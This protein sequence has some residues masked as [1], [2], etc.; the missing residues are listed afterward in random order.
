MTQTARIISD[1]ITDIAPE[2]IEKAADYTG[3]RGAV[4]VRRRKWLIAA[5]LVAALLLAGFTFA[6]VIVRMLNGRTVEWDEDHLFSSGPAADLAEV[7]D[8]RVY[9]TRDNTDITA[10]CSENTYFRYDFQDEQ[11]ISHVILVGGEIDAVGWTEILYF[12]DGRRLSHAHLATEG[13]D[14]AW[15]VAGVAAADE[16]YGYVPPDI[17]GRDSYE[18][19]VT[20][21]IVEN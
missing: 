8:G 20:P 5:A 17:A 19:Q 9:F 15:Y 13:E 16:D 18:F 10:Y 11:G 4:R 1:A 21:E 7:R 6:P 12:Q 2:Y 3:T 14:P